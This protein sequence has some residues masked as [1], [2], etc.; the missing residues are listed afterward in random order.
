MFCTECGYSKQQHPNSICDKN[1]MNTHSECDGQ[2]RLFELA[3]ESDHAFSA[4]VSTF[5]ALS[6]I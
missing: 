6:V 4:T 1:T 2:L 5:E 3:G